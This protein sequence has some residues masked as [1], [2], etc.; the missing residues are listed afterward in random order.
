LSEEIKSKEYSIS[1]EYENHPSQK[2]AAYVG[3]IVSAIGLI[4][5]AE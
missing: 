5:C 4:I 1:N 2:M 3:C